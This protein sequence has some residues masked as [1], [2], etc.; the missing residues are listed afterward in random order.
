[1]KERERERE[2]EKEQEQQREQGAAEAMHGKARDG[3]MSRE[4]GGHHHLLGPFAVESITSTLAFA[5][6]QQISSV[7]LSKYLKVPPFPC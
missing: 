6:L 1:M 3:K 7:L 2:R 4:Q 5:S